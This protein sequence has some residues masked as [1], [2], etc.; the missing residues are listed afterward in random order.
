LEQNLKSNAKILSNGK[1]RS[2]NEINFE[3]NDSL[4]EDVAIRTCF[5]TDLRRAK[6]R[7]FTTFETIDCNYHLP[8]NMV[9]NIPAIV[10]EFAFESIFA[11][12]VDS[13]GLANLIL[14]TIVKSPVDLRKPFVENIVLMG[15]ASMQTGFKSRLVEEIKYLVKNDENYKLFRGIGE[16][17]FHVAPC[18]EN[19]TAW[20]GA[21]IFS[22][23]EV[24]DGLSI[25]N[26]KYKEN[27][28]ILPDWFVLSSKFKNYDGHGISS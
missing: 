2:L 9:L 3:L 10:R 12:D 14:D 6:D 27:N 15:G 16:F 8:N 24:I 17:K 19:Y 1:S 22:T 18:F 4:V 21:S 25:Q 7:N 23:L 13:K 5:V 26:I 11:D 28:E 20:L